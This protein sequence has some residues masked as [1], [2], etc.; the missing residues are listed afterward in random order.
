MENDITIY[1]FNSFSE[2]G[3]V[4]ALWAYGT[5]ITDQPLGY[6]LKI[7]LYQIN[8]FYVESF[9]NPKRNRIFM[10]RAFKSERLLEPYLE[11]IDISSLFNEK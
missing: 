6:N 11:Q 9:Y 3:K 8:D 1:D 5:F 4:C 10:F 7:L 2:T